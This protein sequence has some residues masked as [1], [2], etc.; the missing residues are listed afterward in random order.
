MDRYDW[1]LLAIAIALGG[2]LLVGVLTPVPMVYGLA[3]GFVFATPFVYDAIYRNP[4]LP[5]SDV[6]RAIA[7]IVWHVLL[8]W[9]V[10]AAV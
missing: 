3:T 10:L 7:A 1:I 8:F 6:Q 2:G 5:E 4:P 9:M